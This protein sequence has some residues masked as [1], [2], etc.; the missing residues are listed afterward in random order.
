MNT[1]VESKEAQAVPRL[2]AFSSTMSTVLTGFSQKEEAEHGRGGQ[3]L[4]PVTMLDVARLVFGGR[5]AIEL[6]L[7][8]HDL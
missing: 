6:L 4:V 3:S 1:G 8:C 2:L 5:R 7:Q